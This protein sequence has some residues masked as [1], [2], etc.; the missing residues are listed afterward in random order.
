MYHQALLH[1]NL[2]RKRKGVKSTTIER[3]VLLEQQFIL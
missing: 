2:K 1:L 3:K